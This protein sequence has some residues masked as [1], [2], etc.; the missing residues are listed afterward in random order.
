MG[1]LP[2]TL[3]FWHPAALVATFGG[4]GLLPRAP[5]TWGSLAATLL[6]IAIQRY[7]GTPGLVIAIV[8]AFA[9]GWWATKIYLTRGDDP[10]PGSVVIDEVIGQWITILA[11]PPSAVYY[12]FA[13]LL[14]RFFDIYKPW[15]IRL[16]DRRVPG[17]LGVILDDVLAGVFAAIVLLIAL[18]I[19][20]GI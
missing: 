12:V 19:E 9:V 8:V 16:I 14:F 2:A 10:D 1:Q 5:G 11:V 6:A 3:S 15:P 20:Q 17:A 4:A 18:W 13:F 7:A